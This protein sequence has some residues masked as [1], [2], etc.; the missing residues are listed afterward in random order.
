MNRNIDKD[1]NEPRNKR[2]CSGNGFEYATND[3]RDKRRSSPS[4]GDE[5]GGDELLSSTDDTDDASNLLDNSSATGSENYEQH[6]DDHENYNGFALEVLLHSG[7]VLVLLLSFIF[8]NENLINDCNDSRPGCSE[9]GRTPTRNKFSNSNLCFFLTGGLIMTRIMMMTQL[10]AMYELKKW[11][12]PIEEGDDQYVDD[13]SNDGDIQTEEVDPIEEG[14]DQYVDDG[15]TPKLTPEE[16]LKM[17]G[18][19]EDFNIVTL[20]SEKG[21]S[22]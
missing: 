20:A 22:K 9:P 11:T 19:M 21:W 13:D 18:S 8:A 6:D 1:L 3:G 12:D 17:Y 7:I 5:Y 4:R 15:S 2:S 14:D 10:T 16:I